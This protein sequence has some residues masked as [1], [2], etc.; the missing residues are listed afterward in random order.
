MPEPAADIFREVQQFRQK[1][2]WVIPASPWGILIYQLVS[3]IPLG[4]RPASNPELAVLGTVLFCLF[5]FSRLTTWVKNDGVYFRFFPL[6]FSEQA[7]LF[8]DVAKYEIRIYSPIRDYGGWGI[9]WGPKGKAYNVS[10]NRGIQF[11]LK[12]GKKILIGT[13]RPE[14]FLRALDATGA[15]PPGKSQPACS[16]PL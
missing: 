14:E 5:Y 13:Q 7:I 9:R 11:E 3:G 4:D 1:W 15:S 8:S 2:L 12:N 16:Q 6:H 10:G